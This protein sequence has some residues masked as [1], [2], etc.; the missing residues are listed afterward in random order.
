[1]DATQ[2]KAGVAA[3]DLRKITNPLKR[4][5]K[6]LDQLHHYYINPDIKLN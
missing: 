3:R 5:A 4:I 1:L 6:E 2:L